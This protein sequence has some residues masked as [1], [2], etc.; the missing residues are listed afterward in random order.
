MICETHGT[1]GECVREP[2]CRMMRASQVL[3]RCAHQPSLLSVD[4][5]CS[6]GERKKC[7]LLP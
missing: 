6:D 2:D 5:S 4:L 3:Y 7:S 1:I